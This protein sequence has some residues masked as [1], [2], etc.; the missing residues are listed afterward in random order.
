MRRHQRACLLFLSPHTRAPRKSHVSTQR[1]DGHLQA[2]TKALTNKK[3]S[4]GTSIFNFP[5]SRIIRNKCLLFKP[6]GLVFYYSSHK[7][8][9]DIGKMNQATESNL[10][11]GIRNVAPKLY[12]CLSFGMSSTFTNNLNE[13]V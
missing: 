12:N 7:T 3:K 2:R 1:E 13:G 4:A 9:D 5:I 6:P 10:D 11:G 8:D